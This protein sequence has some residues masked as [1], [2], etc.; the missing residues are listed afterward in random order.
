VN[1]ATGH[2]AAGTDE[3][4]LTQRRKAAK[5]REDKIAAKE[6]KKI[7]TADRRGSE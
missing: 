4:N 5:E 7:R 1:F 3:E 6:R 2:E